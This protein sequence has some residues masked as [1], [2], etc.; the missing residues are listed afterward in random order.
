MEIQ[1]EP[2]L[3]VRSIM[4]YLIY[5]VV[6]QNESILVEGVY[7]ERQ[8]SVYKFQVV[9]LRWFGTAFFGDKY[10]VQPFMFVEAE[11][12]TFSFF[13]VVMR[14]IKGRMGTY[15]EVHFFVAGIFYFPHHINSFSFDAITYT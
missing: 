2:W 5:L 8:K 6:F 10:V 15:L 1:R 3:P 12:A 7:V 4:G 13:C 14:K 9:M 11:E